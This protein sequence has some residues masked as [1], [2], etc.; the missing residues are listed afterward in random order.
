MYSLYLA[1]WCMHPG[2]QN[3][4][5]AYRVREYFL[6][7]IVGWDNTHKAPF[8]FKCYISWAVL[9]VVFSTCV[10]LSYFRG[11]YFNSDASS[12]IAAIQIVPPRV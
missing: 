5:E 8:I 2:S 6:S 4:G 7:L 3:M 12:S 10:S 9:C 11:T 1:S